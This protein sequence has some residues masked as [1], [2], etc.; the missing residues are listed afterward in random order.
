MS[1][2]RLLQLAVALACL[3]PVIGGGMGMAYG[4]AMVDSGPISAAAD[5][6]FRYLS[7]LLLGVGIGFLGTLPRIEAR[8]GRF[9]LLAGIVVIGGLGRLLSV[10]L[11]GRPERW[12]LFALAMELGVTPLLAW[13][14]WRVARPNPK[15]D[16]ARLA[17]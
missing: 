4:P 9:Q 5:S 17:E 15:L 2:R 16:R 12:T 7:G 11:Y 13:W 14:Q 10:L 3:V 6:H 1:E 8:T